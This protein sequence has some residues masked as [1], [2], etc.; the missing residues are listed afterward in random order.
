MTAQVSLPQYQ[1]GP[2]LQRACHRYQ[3]FL[4]L[5]KRSPGSF[6]VPTY[7]IDLMWHAHQV[8]HVNATAEA[9]LTASSLRAYVH[10]R[11]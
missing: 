10:D 6:L 3:A 5:M 11:I 4:H 7:D 1:E 2:F 9:L 8:G